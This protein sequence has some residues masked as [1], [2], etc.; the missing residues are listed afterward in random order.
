VRLILRDA[1]NGVIGS[2]IIPLA[3]L[4]AGAEAQTKN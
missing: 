1:G 2:V 3:R 4:F